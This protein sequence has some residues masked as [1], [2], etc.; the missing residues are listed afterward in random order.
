MRELERVEKGRL[1]WSRNKRKTKQTRKRRMRAK[2]IYRNR[3]NEKKRAR[4]K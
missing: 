3:K 1:K 2:E 4:E